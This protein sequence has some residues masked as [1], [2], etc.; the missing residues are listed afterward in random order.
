[1]RPMSETRGLLS[2]HSRNVQSRPIDRAARVFDRD[3]R[4]HRSRRVLRVC[5]SAGKAR[6]V[7]AM[8]AIS[9]L[10]LST[11]FIL[12]FSL[13]PEMPDRTV[14]ATPLGIVGDVAW[15]DMSPSISPDV[16]AA[17]AFVYDP[18]TDTYV[19][20]GGMDIE[21]SNF[22][23]DTWSYDLG[24]NSWQEL[25]PADH[26]EL[27]VF[28]AYAYD[29][30][31]E[32]MLLFCTV[33]SM[34]NLLNETWSYDA[35]ANDW[36]NLLATNAPSFRAYSSAVYDSQSEKLVMFGGITDLMGVSKFVNET[37]SFDFT[38]NAWTELTPALS[39]SP[40]YLS[41]MAYDSESDRIIV[42]GGYFE[43]SEG[44]GIALADTWSYHFGSNTWTNMTPSL[45]PP[46]RMGA[47]CFYDPIS[48][49]VLVW[50]GA[51]P[52]GALDD[53]WAYDYGTNSWSEVNQLTRP[54]GRAYGSMAIDPTT[55]VAVLFGGASMSGTLGDTWVVQP[56]TPIPEFQ[57]VIL[58]AVGV[59]VMVIALAG[60]MKRARRQRRD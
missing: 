16:R 48:D 27:T 34:F 8:L 30:A 55:G 54:L 17:S 11:I 9:A 25:S 39:P 7:V 42:F 12:P 60:L 18:P 15:T 38:S 5:G 1:M 52:M 3:S 2:E 35:S 13:S 41:S 6:L 36:T 31:D 10:F 58:P 20:F 40:R 45:S 59:I 56:G 47:S 46:E 32:V 37:W 22:F 44:N 57:T 29:S 43:D 51:Q 50:G 23:G 24:A 4:R 28:P 19:L 26:P 53:L 49:S 33:D 21:S 14:P